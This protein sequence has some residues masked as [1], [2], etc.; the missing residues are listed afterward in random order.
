MRKIGIV[1]IALLVVSAGFVGCA[2]A[3]QPLP[4]E[5]KPCDI[6]VSGVYQVF[7]GKESVAH[8]LVLNISNPNEI[9]VT[10]DSLEYFVAFDGMSLGAGQFAQDLYIPSGETIEVEAFFVV[11]LSNLIGAKMLGEGLPPAQATVAAIPLYKWLGGQLGIPAMQ[12]IWD[13]VGADSPPF[14][15]EGRADLA[16]VGGLRLSQPFDIS[17]M[18]TE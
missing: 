8:K 4:T 12:P 18:E 3:A 9:Q 17:W 5:L 10:L 13:G 14:D 11:P 7:G 15:V 6:S 1:I 16:A 2:P